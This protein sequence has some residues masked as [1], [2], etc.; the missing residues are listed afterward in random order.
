[1]VSPELT[2]T[3]S[4]MVQDM[5]NIKLCIE[6]GWARMG[7]SQGSSSVNYQI[8]SQLKSNISKVVILKGVLGS[9]LGFNLK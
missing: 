3:K 7:V 8:I 6:V 9:L 2:K 1:M 4:V 5:Q